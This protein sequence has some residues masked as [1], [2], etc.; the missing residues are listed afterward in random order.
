LKKLGLGTSPHPMGG[1]QAQK[2]SHGRIVNNKMKKLIKKLPQSRIEIEVEIPVEDW[3]DF[4]NEAAKEISKEL[5]VDGFRPGNMPRNVVEREAGLGKIL[6]KGAELAARKTYVKIILEDEIEAIGLPK[7]TI[8]KM[9][10]GNPM[11]FKA[12]T[13]VMPEVELPDYAKIAAKNKSI[14][15][16]K[17][18]VEESEVEGSLNWLAKSRAKYTTISRPAQKGNRVEIDFEARIEGNLIEGGESKNHPFILGQGKFIPGFEDNL[19]GLKEKG[20]KEFKLTF[21]QDYYKKDLAGKEADFKIKMNLVQEEE[22]PEI[23]DDFAKGLG[24]FESL[25][26]LKNNIKEGLLMEKQAREKEA[27]RSKIIEKIAEKT[28]VDIPELLITQEMA[29]MLNELKSKTESFGLPWEKHLEQ[30]GQNEDELK[31]GFRPRA[32]K[33]IKNALTLNALAK[34]EKIEVN[35]FEVEEEINKIL[36]QY[37]DIERAEAKLDLEKAKNHIREILKNEKIFQILEKN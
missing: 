23:N 15:K 34:K 26:K 12:E 7:I 13:A 5:K 16:G 29:N 1:S 19:I 33:R 20:E 27:W 37:P 3:E 8:L 2:H 11:A 32:E 21:P 36:R 10:A 22:I 25:D 30:L 6:E 14:D 31:N 24:G 17:I 28:K 9:A 18:K 35:E 4:L